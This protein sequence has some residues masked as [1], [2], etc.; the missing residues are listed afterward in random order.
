ML[1][2][3]GFEYSVPAIESLSKATN[4]KKTFPKG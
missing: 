2:V 1:V 4:N 3:A